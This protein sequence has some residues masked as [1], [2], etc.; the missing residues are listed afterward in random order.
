MATKPK[1]LCNLVR[2]WIL[3]CFISAC[4]ISM[5]L[6]ELILLGHCASCYAVSADSLPTTIITSHRVDLAFY[7]NVFTLSVYAHVSFAAD[8]SAA[9][10]GL[11]PRCLHLRWMYCIHVPWRVLF[12]LFI[13]LL[14]FP[15]ITAAGC[16]PR[17][18]FTPPS[19]SVFLLYLSPFA[20]DMSVPGR[21]I[22]VV[23]SDQ[24]LERQS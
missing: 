21:I 14:H 6:N 2:R 18:W 5:L 19:Q 9:G 10:E 15:C 1:T 12:V 7:L 23:L 11:L 22:M 20:N 17:S 13:M 4:I 24:C 3:L 16:I 8:T